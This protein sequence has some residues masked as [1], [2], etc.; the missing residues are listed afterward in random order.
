MYKATL[1]QAFSAGK[2]DPSAVFAATASNGAI[3]E[4]TRYCSSHIPE[5]GS[6]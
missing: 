6:S 4:S 2:F 5:R 1:Q 3:A